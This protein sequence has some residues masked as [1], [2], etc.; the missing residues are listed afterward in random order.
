MKTT[1]MK[2][3]IIQTEDCNNKTEKTTEI[4]AAP[5]QIHKST[6]DPTFLTLARNATKN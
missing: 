4:E 1:E 3:K 5:Q 2:D 6:R